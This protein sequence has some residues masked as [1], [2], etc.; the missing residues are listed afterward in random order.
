MRTITL[1]AKVCHCQHLSNAACR[2]LPRCRS[3]GRV[4]RVFDHAPDICHECGMR[5]RARAAAA[6]EKWRLLQAQR[7]LSEFR[8][9]K[10]GRS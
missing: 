8:R 4:L 5:E 3:C 9:V 10:G 6:A 7:L 2:K 1:P